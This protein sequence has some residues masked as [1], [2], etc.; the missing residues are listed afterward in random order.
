MAKATISLKNA[1]RPAP[2]SYRKFENAYFI[3]IAPAV[4]SLIM[5]W[6]FEDLIVERL[7]LAFGF[8]GALV[9]GFGMMLANGQVY[10]KSNQ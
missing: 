6:G 5:G 3:V 8:V 4:V 7:L 10:T 9:K 2:L 1:N